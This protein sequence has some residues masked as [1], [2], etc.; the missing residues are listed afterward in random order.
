MAYKR[1]ISV[2]FSNTCM[3]TTWSISPTHLLLCF[4]LSKS[5]KKKQAFSLSL[6]RSSVCLSM[7]L[8]TSVARSKHWLEGAGIRRYANIADK[9][10]LTG[11]VKTRRFGPAKTLVAYVCQKVSLRDDKTCIPKNSKK[12]QQSKRI[13]VYDILRPFPRM[14]YLSCQVNFILD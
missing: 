14:T 1:I 9:G 11:R 4:V 12:Q 6:R 8:P 10:I 3:N 2:S 5:K 7:T 13:D